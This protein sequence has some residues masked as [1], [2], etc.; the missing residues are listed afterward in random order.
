MLKLK[1]TKVTKTVTSSRSVGLFSSYVVPFVFLSS[2]LLQDME[3][4]SRSR[5]RSRSRSR[6]PPSAHPAERSISRSRSRSPSY[7]RSPRR[8]ISP[9]SKSGSRSRS[10]TPLPR[11]SRNGHRAHRDI[12]RSLT[13]SRSPSRGAGGRRYRERSY[14]RSLSRHG[15]SPQSSKIVVE[16][17]T[18]NVNEAHLREIFG[19]YGQIESLDM[20]M[21]RQCTS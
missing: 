17:L 19:S 16:K 14:T 5:G 8:S 21:N 13:R 18:K 4:R 11:D 20:P 2:Y 12:S 3:S 15:R 1:Y 7:S 6:T 10:H 9:R